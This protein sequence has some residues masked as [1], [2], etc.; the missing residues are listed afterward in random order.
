MDVTS[1]KI[2]VINSQQ[3]DDAKPRLEMQTK[4][5]KLSYNHLKS[6]E[7]FETA[8]NSILAEANLHWID[9]S[10]NNLESIDPVRVLRI[11]MSCI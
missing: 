7:G 8:V 9:L 3:V 11:V 5:I 2:A 1:Q 4:A 6:L 10:H